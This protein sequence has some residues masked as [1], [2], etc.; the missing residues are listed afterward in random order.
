M[1]ERGEKTWKLI[2]KCV[3]LSL[4]HTAFFMKQT[5][6]ALNKI[7]RIEFVHMK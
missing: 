4:C 1:K 2:K 7:H 5:F 3:L 6:A